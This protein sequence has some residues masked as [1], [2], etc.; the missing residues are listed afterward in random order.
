MVE[1]MVHFKTESPFN[2]SYLYGE[3]GYSDLS[4]IYLKKFKSQ[5][6][7]YNTTSKLCKKPEVMCVGGKEI[8]LKLKC[9]YFYDISASQIM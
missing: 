5:Y 8:R 9:Y 2:V 1:A 6:N 3:M 7:L 4:A